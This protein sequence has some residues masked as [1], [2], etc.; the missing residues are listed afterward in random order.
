MLKAKTGKF[1]FETSAK[2]C[3]LAELIVRLKIKSSKYL[4]IFLRVNFSPSA[5][6][7]KLLVLQ[8]SRFIILTALLIAVMTVI[9]ENQLS[10]AAE[11]KYVGLQKCQSCHKK[12]YQIWK[13]RGHSKAFSALS[14]KEK[15]DPACLICH[16]TGYGKPAVKQA[17]LNNVQCEVCHGPGS[18]YKNKKIMSKES[19]KKDPKAAQAKAMEAGLILPDEKVCVS[20]HNEKSPTFKGFDFKTYYEK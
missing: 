15:K 4:V 3:P 8:R 17:K 12:Q 16:T 10:E 2:L 19:Y 7:T 18:L 11:A 13:T 14:A 1:Y 6:S 9:L 20:C 5:I